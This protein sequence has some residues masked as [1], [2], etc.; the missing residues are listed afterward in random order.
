MTGNTDRDLPG[1]TLVDREAELP[2]DPEK[3]AAICESINAYLAHRINEAVEYEK[4]SRFMGGPP[5][6]NNNPC[7]YHTYFKAIMPK[8]VRMTLWS[9]ENHL[10]GR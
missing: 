3:T 10:M 7:E 5:G 4:Y 8:E 6:F 2:P 9:S 1:G